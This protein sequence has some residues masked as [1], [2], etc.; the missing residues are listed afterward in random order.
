M[1]R[2]FLGSSLLTIVPN[3]YLTCRFSPSLEVSGS[4]GSPKTWEMSSHWTQY[5]HAIPPTRLTQRMTLARTWSRGILGILG[6]RLISTPPTLTI[7]R[8]RLRVRLATVRKMSVLIPPRRTSAEE[9]VRRKQRDVATQRKHDRNVRNFNIP[10]FWPLTL[11]VL[12]LRCLRAR[13]LCRLWLR[14]SFLVAWRSRMIRRV[15]LLLQLP[16]SRM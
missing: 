10:M 14:S 9:T 5:R 2:F 4:T 12:L 3:L 15:V 1:K 16:C 7:L 8:L 6:T 11:P 13:R